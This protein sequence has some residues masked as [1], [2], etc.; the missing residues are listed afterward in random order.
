MSALRPSFFPLA[1]AA[2]WLVACAPSGGAPRDDGDALIDTADGGDVGAGDDGP[3]DPS[4]DTHLASDGDATGDGGGG[5]GDAGAGD[6]GDP[7]GG[8]PSTNRRVAF[9]AIG[10]TGE[11]NDVQ[12]QVAQAIAAKCAADGCDFVVLLGDNFYPSGVSSVDDPQWQT[13]FEQ[14][15]AGVNVP[16]YAALGNHDYGG[17]GAGHEFWKGPVQV[18]YAAQSSKF[19]MPDLF[20]AFALGP[21]GFVVLDTNMM[22]YEQDDDQRGWYADAVAA[23]GTTWTVVVGHHPYRSNGPHGN[24]GNYEG[25]SWLPVASGKGVK[26]F[27][28][29]ILCGSADLYISGHDHSRQWLTDRW[30]GT[31]LIVSGAGAKHT[32]LDPDRNPF[33]F[34]SIDEGFFYCAIQ[35]NRLT[36]QF[37]SKAGVLEYERTITK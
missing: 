27:F 11:G 2:A 28:D 35:G 14:P 30:C 6:G 17:D 9:V 4:G 15:Y 24:A 26:K 18:E 25:F 31:E 8:D 10:D 32:E 21:L 3:S 36:G 23:L 20:Y 5:G 29:E 16:F 19:R 37:I 13:S 1:A 12:H 34:Q 22:M 7:T 33:N